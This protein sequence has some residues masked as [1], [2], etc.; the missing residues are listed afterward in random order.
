VTTEAVQGMCERRGRWYELR[1]VETG[2]FLGK[3]PERSDAEAAARQRRGYELVEVAP[4]G[5]GRV[6]VRRVGA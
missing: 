2:D 4:L 1:S 6:R 5:P 3:W